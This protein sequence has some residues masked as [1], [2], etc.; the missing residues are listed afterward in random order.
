MIFHI[1]SLDRKADELSP[2]RKQKN[3]FLFILKAT[4][5]I[6]IRNVTFMIK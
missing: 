1:Y 5:K 6:I 3:T 4:E 2:F